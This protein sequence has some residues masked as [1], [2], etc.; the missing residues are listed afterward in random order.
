MTPDNLP[1]TVG[2]RVVTVRQFTLAQTLARLSGKE[3]NADDPPL[4]PSDSA[5]EN[6]S[7]AIEAMFA[8]DGMSLSD[9]EAFSDFNR[10]KDGDALPEQLAALV[11]K[12]KAANPYFFAQQDALLAA[13]GRSQS[14]E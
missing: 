13:L 12:I 1:V 6:L 5:Q 9:M 2:A 10:E 11:K 7:R 8:V 4:P 3:I 14:R